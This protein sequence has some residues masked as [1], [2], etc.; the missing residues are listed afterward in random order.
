MNLI[1]DAWI[2]VRR[3]DGTTE[4]IE[5]WRIT[6]HV[7]N[8]NSPIVA[9]ASPRPDFD[10][11]LTQFLIGLLQT[12]CTPETE[13]AWW[14]WLETPPPLDVLRTRF[15]SVTHAFALDGK[16][17][18]M[19]DFNPEQLDKRFSIAA[20]LIG[21][22]GENSDTDL[23]IKQGTVNQ[24]CPH[25]VAAAVFS[26]QTNA[27]EGGRGYRTGLR[28]GG[29][30]TTLVMGSS[31]WLTCWNNVLERT[32]YL[33]GSVLEKQE[34]YDRFPWL[35]T[36]RTSEGKP[37]A[38]ITTSIDV[39]PDQQYW[40]LPRRIRLVAE[41]TESAICDVCGAASSQIHRYFLTKNY[42]VNYV[43][44]EHPLSPHYVKD[45]TLLPIHPRPGGIGYRY[46]LGLVVGNGDGTHKP[47]RVIAQYR[48]CTTKDGLLWAFGYDM[49][50]N[51][52][53]CWYDA[54]M[55]ILTIEEGLESVFTAQV[56][57]LIQSANWVSDAL[58]KR[59]MDALFGDVDARGDIGFVQMHFCADTEVSFFGTVR[60]LRDAL[61]QGT[62]DR[63]ILENWLSSLRRAALRVFDTYSQT[64]DFDATDP[65]RV[66][67]ARNE[68]AKALNG[69]KLRDLLGLPRQERSVA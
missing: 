30:L 7:G 16:K 52:A 23:F 35:A 17:A 69:K 49:K 13:T 31:L 2:P 56:E 45:N 5:P 67:L 25:C 9:V 60:Q 27:P 21:S 37:P 57:Q 26:L 19:Q 42:G 58:R 22:P 3:A 18:F 15:R 24:L 46:W 38:G 68:L 39:H 59:V 29:P 36:T 43:G 1:N 28:G 6:D 47:A 64:G 33:G 61:K 44:F 50:S 40:A 14:D 53:R 63:Q 65:R 62:G 54:V 4:K 51:K 11:A 32:R 34:D 8:D 12:T 10:G 48:T 55:P 66:A 41:E 20:L